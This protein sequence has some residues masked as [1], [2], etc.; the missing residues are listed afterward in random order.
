M[1]FSLKIIGKDYILKMTTKWF[2][3][4]TLHLNHWSSRVFPS[5]DLSHSS[6]TILTYLFKSIS[7][8]LEGAGVGKGESP[9]FSRALLS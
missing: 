8:H 6:S 4:C 1:L 2:T 5:N 7:E 3:I 9:S